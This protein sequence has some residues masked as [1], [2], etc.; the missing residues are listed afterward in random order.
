MTNK[1]ILQGHDPIQINELS[2]WAQWF[3][4]A[5]RVVAK[6]ILNNVTIST[7]FLGL[8][9]SWGTGLP[10]LFETLVFGGEMDG[11]MNRYSTWDEAVAGHN[12]MVNIVKGKN[13]CI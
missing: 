1:Y 7:V 4:T 12:R 10:V 9:H 6:T 13:S 5:D 8:D 11:E 2:D 3:E